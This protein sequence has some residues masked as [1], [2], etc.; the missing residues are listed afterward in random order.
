MLFFTMSAV[1]LRPP[2]VGDRSKY[3]TGGW[4]HYRALLES[5]SLVF[6]LY[7]A[8]EEI[9]DYKELGARKYFHGHGGWPYSINV[10]WVGI[11]L[12]AIFRYGVPEAED[13]VL[14]MACFAAWTYFLYYLTAFQF[15]VWYGGNSPAG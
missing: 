4:D 15:P 13:I 3:D 7:Y 2:H 12:S 10:Y 8:W 14:S 9:M 6:A 1:M 5:I 11:L